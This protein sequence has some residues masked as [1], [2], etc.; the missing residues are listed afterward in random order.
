MEVT[1]TLAFKVFV[2][3][4][5]F[6]GLLDMYIVQLLKSISIRFKTDKFI[7]QNLKWASALPVMRRIIGDST[8]SYMK[9]RTLL[10]P[11]FEI[12]FGSL[13]VIS[14]YRHGLGSGFIRTG[15]FLLIAMLL[16]MI[17]WH[18]SRTFIAPNLITYPG[19]V[20]GVLISLI[21]GPADTM[22]PSALIRPVTILISHSPTLANPLLHVLNSLIG[23][24][25]GG[26]ALWLM[27][28]A[29]EKL[30]GIEAIG[31]GAIK[32]G[33]MI[34]AFCGWRLA[35]LTIM[36]ASLTG[37]VYGLFVMLR[38][39]QRDIVLHLPFPPFLVLGGIVAML[40]GT[41]IVSWYADQFNK[42]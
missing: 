19:T 13:I 30:K 1:P 21:I 39:R 17:S 42:K 35:I 33:M 38:K 16:A 5:A 2:S 14:L 9:S 27:G 7:N 34:G 32:T 15:V 6:A 10:F 29:W 36:L 40:W 37:S 41:A 20:I 8:L 26:G 23:A 25:I 22:L 24:F 18:D 31:L 12:A 28:W 11:A 3:A 4:I